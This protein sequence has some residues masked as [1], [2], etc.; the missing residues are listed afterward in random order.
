MPT[1][2]NDLQPNRA[3]SA[4]G[5]RSASIQ[6]HVREAKATE[7]FNQLHWRHES[8]QHTFTPALALTWYNREARYVID[9]Q[10]V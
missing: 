6:S 7:L 8:H 4:D 5:T 1:Q 2:P 9:T 10:L 3:H